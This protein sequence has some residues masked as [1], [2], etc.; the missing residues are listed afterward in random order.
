MTTNPNPNVKVNTLPGLQIPAGLSDDQTQFF[1]AVKEHLQILQ[2]VLGQPKSRAVTLK[3]L[4]DA[5]LIKVMTVGRRAEIQKLLVASTDVVQNLSDS[6][7]ATGRFDG[8]DDTL[9]ITPA[10]GDVPRYRAST[11]KWFNGPLLE[12]DG[13]LSLSYFPDSADVTAYLDVFTDALNGLVPA[14]VTEAGLFLRDDGTWQTVSTSAAGGGGGTLVYVNTDPFGAGSIVANT[15]TP[16]EFDSA[17]TFEAD[18]LESG[19]VIRAVFRGTA[20][21]GTAGGSVLKLRLK[22]NGTTVLELAG[23]SATS[24]AAAASN[25][26]WSFWM[27]LVVQTDGVAGTAEVQGQQLLFSNARAIGNAATIVL[28]TTIDN[29]F[30][31]EAEWDTA[32]AAIT[33]TLHEMMVW[34]D[35]VDAL[36]SADATYYT[37]ES[38]SALANSY[39]LVEGSGIELD[40]TTEGEVA[41]DLAPSFASVV[42]AENDDGYPGGSV[43]GEGRNVQI[44]ADDV[45]GTLVIDVLPL[46][47]KGAGWSSTTTAS[48]IAAATAVLVT[49]P[50]KYDCFIDNVT[51]TTQGGSGSC[52]IN[53]SRAAYS[54][55]P[56]VASIVGTNKPTIVSDTKYL[57]TNL[58]GWTRSLSAGDVLV[59]QLESC[60]TFTQISCVLQLRETA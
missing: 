6:V 52:V 33:T 46:H 28:N 50:V 12:A 56:T 11:G 45:P 1:K 14:P 42:L 58:A 60:S 7:S 31:L 36:A 2:G 54:G 27:D 40:T 48:A 57:D 26:G 37:A 49:V 16:T 9:I 19:H 39:T 4:E 18:R 44:D 32:D 21:N 59:F 13:S 25:V 38:E 23:A 3:D 15:T 55:F 35:G 41:I 10:E 17:Y 24:I 34:L 29:E 8:L 5:G 22:I 53:I 30:T 51:V 20:S 47:E 43:L